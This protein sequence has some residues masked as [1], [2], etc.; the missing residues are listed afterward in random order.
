M[1]AP[2]VGSEKKKNCW[3]EF[4]VVLTLERRYLHE[5]K[6]K[7]EIEVVSNLEME[8]GLMIPGDRIIVT[9]KSHTEIKIGLRKHHLTGSKSIYWNCLL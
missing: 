8:N 6:Q 9:T 5:T 2:I 1:F 4:P 3:K 7:M